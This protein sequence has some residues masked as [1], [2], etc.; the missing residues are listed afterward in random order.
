MSEGVDAAVAA[1][2]NARDSSATLKLAL[3]HVRGRLPRLAIFVFEGTDDKVPYR[4]WTQRLRPGLAFEPLPCRGKGNVLLLRAAVERDANDLKDGVYFFV[5]RDFDDLRGEHPSEKT[6]MTETYSFEN[7]LVSRPVLDLLLA[8]VFH[9]DDSESR[10]RVTEDF[11]KD[12]EAF[13]TVTKNINRR[14]F[15]CRKAGIQCANLPDKIAKVANV[16]LNRVDALARP[17]AE[18]VRLDREPDNADQ[19]KHGAAFD[20]LEPRSRYRGKFA[21][22]FFMK[23]LQLLADDR[24]SE[25]SQYFAAKRAGEPKIKLE[26][27]KV[28]LLASYSD[29]PKGLSEFLSRVPLTVAA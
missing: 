19:D 8:D 29:P 28:G 10:A 3:L 5:D 22:M 20:L 13:L 6:F 11:E 7:S 12:Y 9:C 2:I 16:S 4:V 24:N 23:W 14:I 21:L 27:I 17:V 26:E 1:M 15:V 25:H 18:I